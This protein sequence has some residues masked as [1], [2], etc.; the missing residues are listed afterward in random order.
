MQQGV[1]AV[2]QSFA[3]DDVYTPHVTPQNPDSAQ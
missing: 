2:V 3:Y 1:Q